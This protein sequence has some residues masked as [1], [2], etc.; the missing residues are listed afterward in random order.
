MSTAVI[1]SYE[2]AIENLPDEAFLGALCWFSISQADVNLEEARENLTTLGLN[3]SLLKSVIRPVDAFRKASREVAHKFHAN[4]GVKSELLVR[5][6]GED[7]ET[8]HRHLILE[9]AVVKAGQKRRVFYEKVG[10]IVFTRGVKKDGAYSGY[11]VDVTR[12]T[13]NLTSPLTEEEETWLNEKL[14]GFEERF[15]HMLEFMDSH[16]VRTFVRDYIDSLSGTCVKESGGLYFV[17]QKHA[18]VVGKLG[19]WVRGIGSEFHGLPLLNIAE[20]RQMIAESFE[21]ETLTEVQRLG[22]EI[23]RILSD[24]NRTIEDKTFQ[25]YGE[26]AADLATRVNE[27]HDMLDTRSDR[28]STEIRLFA[29]QVMSLSSRIRQPKAKI[30]V[31]TPEE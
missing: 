6:V 27:Y 26:R 17:G 4:D 20:Q 18:E 16:S 1:A 5:S 3:A 19:E 28:A 9:R 21:S 31:T 10:E 12:T 24:P 14:D 30:K 8:C 7:G 22:D 11:S 2:E 13:A 25:A 23:G 29:A 15:N